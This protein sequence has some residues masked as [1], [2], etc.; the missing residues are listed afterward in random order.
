MLALL[1]GAVARR[2]AQAIPANTRGVRSYEFKTFD[3][4][5]D[6]DHIY[7]NSDYRLEFDFKPVGLLHFFGVTATI[8]SIWCGWP[9]WAYMLENYKTSSINAKYEKLTKLTGGES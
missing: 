3:K 1:R 7:G 2:T 9:V 4:I 5:K 8:M 6:M